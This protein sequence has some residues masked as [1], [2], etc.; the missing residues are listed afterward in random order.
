MDLSE[1]Q[2][3][4]NETSLLPL[5]GP[6][7]AIQPLLG[8][9]YESGSILNVFMRY[10]RDNIDLKENIEQLKE[11]LGDL[12][13]Y[14]AAVATAAG[15]DLGEI[16]DANLERARDRYML[17]GEEPDLS[18]LEVYDES[19]PERERFP[20]RLQFD[21]METERDGAPLAIMRL[22]FAD[23]NHFPEGPVTDTNEKIAGFKVGE[24]LGDA[25]T[26]N[27]RIADGYRYHD[28]IHFGFMAVLGWSPNTRSLLKLK[29]RSDATVDECEDGARAIFAEEGLATI[30]SRLA[31]RRMGFLTET[32]VDGETVELAKAAT[33][34]F[35]VS[36]APAWLWRRAISSGFRAMRNLIDHKGG[37]LIADLDARTLI[38]S[39][40]PLLS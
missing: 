14:A 9:A 1:Y 28:A 13:W 26:D 40:I 29:R 33:S 7:A 5:G 15:L 19:F 39:K 38:Y 34:S 35:E 6:V 21:F 37:S 12:L 30:L 16:A 25:L 10:M 22:T 27:A 36:S 23:P 32:T 20:R 31:T 18:T 17:R 2:Q 11:E 3:K 24:N 4:A 8:L